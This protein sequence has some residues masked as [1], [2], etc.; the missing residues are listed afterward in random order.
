MPAKKIYAHDKPL[1][2]ELVDQLDEEDGVNNVVAQHVYKMPTANANSADVEYLVTAT[3]GPP[4]EQVV[5]GLTNG[6]YYELRIRAINDQGE[7][8]SR[9]EEWRGCGG[10]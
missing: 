4:Y 9:S 8:D 10:L 3:N 2:P 6:K 7:A 1:K 5:S